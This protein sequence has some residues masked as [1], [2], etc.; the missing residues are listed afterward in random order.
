MTLSKTRV[1]YS[2]KLENLEVILIHEM[3]E[4]AYGGGGGGGGYDMNTM[5]IVCI[6]RV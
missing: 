4:G 5:N 3:S 6:R 2:T 1:H